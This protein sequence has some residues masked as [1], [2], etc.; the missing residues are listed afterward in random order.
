[1][2]R[3]KSSARSTMLGG[4]ARRVHGRRRNPFRS[5]TLGVQPRSKTR[6]LLV[7]GLLAGSLALLATPSANAVGE[8]LSVTLGQVDGAAPFDA[9]SSAGH[10]AN[11]T[12]GI[13]RT[14]DTLTYNVELRVDTAPS[15]GTTFTVPLPKG[16]EMTLVP[17][18]C[19][20][21]G[22]GLT[23]ASLG[24]PAVPV[25]AT[26]WTALPTQS[27]VCNVGNRTGN[28]TVTYPVVAKVRPEVPNGTNLTLASVSA[29]S[30]DVTTPAESGPVQATVSARAQFNISKNGMAD[31]E[32]T[33]PIEANAGIVACPTASN[34]GRTCY[35]YGLPILINAPVGGKGVTPM[36]PTVTFT[37]DLSPTSL[38]P[39]GVTTDPDWIAAGAGALAKYG[40][41]LDGCVPQDNLQP[42]YKIGAP[43]G[44]GPL[45]A[46]NSVRDS[47]TTTCTQAGGPGTPVS[48]AINNM[49]STAYTY[50]TGTTPQGNVPIP[51]DKAYVYSFSVRFSIP[52][53]AVVDLGLHAP[54]GTSWTLNWDNKYKDFAPAGIDGAPNLP[55]ANVVLDDHRASSSIVQIRGSFQKFYT[56]IPG[57]PGNTPPAEF[58][59]ITNGWQG[60][61]GSTGPQ[62]GEGQIFAGQVTTSTL[63]MTN[64]SSVDTPMTYLACDAWDPSRLR[65]TSKVQPGGADIPGAPGGQSYQ[66]QPSGGSP[67]W[68]SG[69]LSGVTLVQNPAL[70]PA[71]QVEYGTGPGGS[72]AASQCNDNSS[73]AGW[74]TNPNAAALGN[75][76][77][78]AAQGV[79]TGV[80][81]VRVRVV[82]PHVSTGFGSNLAINIGLQ[83]TPDL[84][85]GTILPNW[86]NAKQGF[87]DFTLAQMLDPARAWFVNDYNPADNGGQYGDR[88]RTSPG[89]ARVSKQVKDPGTGNF[90]TSTPQFTG[91]DTAQFRLQPTLSAGITADVRIPMSVE[92]CLPVGMLFL[93]DTSSPAASLVQTGSPPGAGLTCAAG[94]TYVRWDLGPVQIN[95]VIPPITYSVRVAKGAQAGTKTNTA[96][97]TAEGDVSGTAAR[98][99]TASIQVVQ[100]AGIVVDKVALTPEVEVNRAGET[101]RDPL[102]W[103]IEFS[104]VNSDPGPTDVDMI[105]QLPKQGADGTHYNGTLAFD[106]ATVTT[107]D[108]PGQPV[109]ILYTRAVNV[110]PDPGN[111][112]NHPT[113]GGTIWC[114]LSGTTFT[115]VLGSGTNAGCPSS[116]SAVTGLRIRRPGAFGPAAQIG[117]EV[118]M[119]PSSN[120]AGDV[121]VNE[122]AGRAQG[123]AL[124]VG[125]A[126][127]PATVVASS[128]GNLVWNDLNHNGIQDPKEPPRPDFKVTLTGTD[129]DGNTVGPMSTTTDADGKYQFAGLQSGTYK[130]TFDPASLGTNEYFTYQ[131]RID[132]TAPDPEAVD[133]D[134]N[135]TTGVANVTLE[136]D[137][138]DE[139]VD[140]GVIVAG[141]DI[142]I[143]KF[144]NGDNANTKPGVL[145]EPGSDMAVT[146]EVHN[147]GNMA[148]DPVV[149]TDDTIAAGAINCPEATLAAGE[150][151]TCTATYPAPDAGKQHTNVATA[152]GTPVEL[153][154]G[155]QLDDVT[156]DD[157]ANA[158]GVV[159]QV[160]ITKDL[161]GEPVANGDGTYSV[162][163]DVKVAN[164]GTQPATYD[165]D[166][167]LHFGTGATVTGANVTSGP[168]GVS[169]NPAWNG[170][171][172]TRIASA[173]DTPVDGVHT[174]RVKATASI[175]TTAATSASSDCD[176]TSG[177][178]GTGFLNGATLTFDGEETDV[179]A[180]A[181]FPVTTFD[182]TLAGPPVANGD[183]THTIS[184]DIEVT[185]TGAAA[186]TYDLSDELRYGDD[187]TVTAATVANT[188][189]GTITTAANWNGATNQQIVS[190]QAI[191]AGGSQIYRVTVIA[192]VQGTITLEQSD[193]NLQ[194]GEKGTGFLNGATLTVNGIKTTDEACAEAPNTSMTKAL[195]GDPVVNADKSVTSTYVITVKNTGAAADTYDLD[196]EL[197]FGDDITVNSA[198]VTNSAPGTITTNSGWNGAG[199]TEIVAGEAIASGATHTYVV[200]VNATIGTTTTEAQAD[201]TKS[202]NEN[203]TGF[204]NGATLSVNG[205]TSTDEA[206]GE[207][208]P[209]IAMD[210]TLVGKPVRNADGT[211]EV[212]Y[213]IEVSNTVAPNTYDLSDELTFGR[214][215]VVE[216]A[217]VTNTDPGTI[218]T[219]PSWN[220][221]TKRAIVTGEAIGAGVSHTYRVVVTATVPTTTTAASTDC[222]LAGSETGTGFLNG[223]T[224]KTDEETVDD[225]ACAPAPNVSIAKDLVGDPVVN[226]DNTVDL[227]Y[228]VTVTNS[229][230][231]ADTYDLDDELQFGNDITVNN[232]SVTNLTPG[233]VTLNPGWNGIAETTVATDVDIAGAA[234]APA[235]HVYVVKVNATVGSKT[236]V[237]E[238]DCTLG[239]GETGTGFLNNA[240]LSIDEH[241]TDD[242]AC[243][244]VS[245][246]ITVAKTMVGKPSANGDGT[247]TTDYDV[248]A[249]NVGPTPGSYDLDDKLAYGQ[250]VS[251]LSAAVKNTQPGTITTNPDWDGINDVGVVRQ[252][253]IGVGGAQTYRVTVTS[254]VA[255]GL[256][257]S[258]SDCELGAGEA[259]TGFLNTTELTY[260]GGEGEAK[261]CGEI[262]AFTIVKKIKGTPSVSK[263]GAVE[264]TY[265][266]TVTNTGKAEGPYLLRDKI[267]WGAGLSITSAK[268]TSTPAGQTGRADW[269]GTT[270][271]LIAEN[272]A[273]AADSTHV[274]EVT[275]KGQRSES[276]S[277]TAGD[278]TLGN[279]EGG[280]GLLNTATVESNGQ[281]SDS[282][283]CAPVE[284]STRI[285]QSGQSGQPGEPGQPSAPWGSLPRTGATILGLVLAGL[286]LVGAGRY[287]LGAG[288]RRSKAMGS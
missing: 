150:T 140:Q 173:V 166:D 117:L 65:L 90:G 54:G 194:G 282:E 63:W 248:I 155:T 158:Y 58:D 226:D 86:A 105:D 267:R 225:D 250:N 130:V 112:T 230:A 6:L 268:V 134:G 77:T 51:A 191:A 11:G 104:N 243:G 237:T 236:T 70:Y 62:T 56:G 31:A 261:A 47:G 165:L 254:S 53:E 57:A 163:Y 274:W 34:P 116:V 180:C 133:S 32:N 198:T 68:A 126:L 145:V 252:E 102:K 203:G 95:S 8:S 156:D 229:G 151:M 16:V 265:S 161:V 271:T 169:L 270:Q 74:H 137:T 138:N 176:L 76:P 258:A 55:A 38:Y 157:P 128:I 110:D 18:Y 154:D 93:V 184:Y 278:C 210:K 257:A 246:E 97:V 238:A 153:P 36:S 75:D 81:R 209:V 186:D 207:A 239:S 87:G 241:E 287:L 122:V 286:T 64:R 23:P 35:R 80:S 179:D 247:W 14:N 233:D 222:T 4:A 79:Y 232:A 263:S 273:L 131:D 135:P 160:D 132:P 121:Y 30:A 195:F 234:A 174:Y 170:S 213:D 113:T 89:V 78:L 212:T 48:I 193:C 255:P 19:S 281:G 214:G 17:P 28:S 211:W 264:V 175:S 217:S 219:N 227:T 285:S 114:S 141:P 196:D 190:G 251:V 111:T 178:T 115:R 148:L 187:I 84:P 50:P 60:P 216:D 146:F 7:I 249:T 182:K 88:L 24:A 205:E 3:V 43:S 199:D 92:D 118:Q 94:E 221:L 98:T 152:T 5:L 52:T 73:P 10:D 124:L 108:E 197:H 125:P 269:N 204:S 44:G 29:V 260:P 100:P 275:V 228:H 172:V 284:P 109:E 185:N 91:G 13:V 37:D 242:D 1:M 280:T 149:I 41:F 171:D 144:I 262:P 177:E 200:T 21:P 103:L 46:T 181:P 162:T 283:V 82:L 167:Q 201:C 101:T 218:T 127:A 208:K 119:T 235:V 220:G 202:Q 142:E 240:V 72:G 107:G 159:R 136:A 42:G 259:G 168:A 288:R 85:A 22:S 183:G 49:D 253:P 223:A 279:G 189:P 215:I 61:A 15:T 40:A 66:I 2:F 9:D 143:T 231:G 106:S 244:E 276:M 12:N 39:A 277:T 20:G 59:P 71:L 192:K 272:V 224:V 83:A 256:T 139:N 26:S 129:S 67:V 123:L 147:N 69:Y 96:M 33:G 164:K 45:T 25:T 266:L 27:L 206:C 99:A 120:K 188:V 245:Q